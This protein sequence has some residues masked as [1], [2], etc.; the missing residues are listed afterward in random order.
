MDAALAPLIARFQADYSRLI[1]ADMPADHRIALAVSG[2][3]DSMAMLGLAAAAFPGRVIAATIDHGLR[4]ESAQEAAM[5]ARACTK[6]GVPHAIF[7]IESPPSAGDNVQSWARQERYLR[8]K[9]WAFDADAAVLCTAH[10]AED[11]AETFLMRAARASGL[12][13]L[14]AV[15]ARVETSIGTSRPLTLLRPLLRWRRADL[16]SAAETMRL[17]WIDDPSNSDP[18]FD[19]ARFRAWLREAPWID[20]VQ[21][22]RTAENMAAIDSDLIE[23]SRWLWQSRALE[24]P[25]GESRFDVAG[26]PRG[27]KRYIARIAIDAIVETSSR[28]AGSWSYSSNVEPLLDALEAGGSATQ[29][30]IVASAKGD[31]WHF[32]EAPPR[33]SH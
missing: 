10:H 11:Q 20:P 22:G 2:G 19:R 21:I 6:M 14:A 8:L 27:V 23:I 18:R 33:R 24:A 29:S 26:L 4:P 28:D 3:P 13:G 9:R 30:I 7:A 5:V 15:R 1:G 17:P 16:R 32:R 25:D 31:I 12:S